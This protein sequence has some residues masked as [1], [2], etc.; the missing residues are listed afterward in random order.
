MS[1]LFA[2]VSPSHLDRPWG[3]VPCA[4]LSLDNDRQE[5]SGSVPTACR[6]FHPCFS[7]GIGSQMRNSNNVTLSACG[8][9]DLAQSFDLAHARPF[10]RIRAS[11]GSGGHLCHALAKG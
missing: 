7:S 9:F 5:H 6:R 4:R 1:L 11:Q 8:C 3:L 2:F 10:M